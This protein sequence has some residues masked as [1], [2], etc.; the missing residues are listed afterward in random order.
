MGIVAAIIGLGILI[1]VHEFGHFVAA[2]L[3]RIR[4]DE[5]SVGFG[6]KL[7]SW[8]R[9]ETRYAVSALPFG[10]YVR[11]PGMDAGEEI[12]K[13]EE[14]RAFRAKSL[15]ARFAVIVAGPAMNVLLAVPI[16]AAIFLLGIP[17]PTTTIAEV[18]PDSGAAEAGIQPGDR[19]VKI[20]GGVVGDWQD[21]I[22]LIQSNANQTVPIV[23]ERGGEEVEVSASIGE[24]KEQGVTRAFLG[25]R[26]E[27]ETVRSGP[28]R[29]LAQGARATYDITSAMLTV[30]WMLI[31]GQLPASL[32]AEGSLGPVGIIDISSDA[33]QRG[34]TDFLRLLGIIS[35]NLAIVNLLPIPP[36]D[37]GR[38]AFLGWE[39]VTRRAV[40]RERI[41]QFQTIGLAFLLT[42]LIVFTVSDV[43]RIFTGSPRLPGG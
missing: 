28:I 31:S 26:I 11:M 2:K 12:P 4:V 8:Q 32:L 17:T 14:H 29:A 37:G 6:P 41:M 3:F 15:P 39:A 42:L 34:I 33:A 35:P 25:V 24:V 1:L 30:L 21:A 19:L 27:T 9:G 16:F 36:L 23:L 20:D 5:F 38:V 18:T 22:R 43:S 7:F 10:G 40:S 13:D